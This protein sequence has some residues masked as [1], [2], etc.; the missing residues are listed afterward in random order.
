MLDVL[1]G[2]VAIAVSNGSIERH[3]DTRSAETALRAKQLS[4]ALLDRMRVGRRADAF[5]CE[6][7]AA[8]HCDEWE[9]ACIDRLVSVWSFGGRG[10]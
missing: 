5:Y 10:R 4:D 7:V 1:F 3:D 9:Q 2:K 6:D 8:M